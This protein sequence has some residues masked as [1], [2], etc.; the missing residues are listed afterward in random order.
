[1]KPVGSRPVGR[2]RLGLGP[3]FRERLAQTEQSTKTQI[4][5]WLAERAHLCFLFSLVWQSSERGRKYVWV[6]NLIGCH[7]PLLIE[8]L[9]AVAQLSEE[10]LL[11]GARD[12]NS[13]TA[14]MF[15]LLLANAPAATPSP[16]YETTNPLLPWDSTTSLAMYVWR[17]T[18]WSYSAGNFAIW[19]PALSYL[20]DRMWIKAELCTVKALYWK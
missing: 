20:S 10:H 5:V 15:C 2:H 19:G 4:S 8:C 12:G 11:G 17:W 6:N 1:M 14:W 18:G 16:P 3:G 13:R 7:V 9:S